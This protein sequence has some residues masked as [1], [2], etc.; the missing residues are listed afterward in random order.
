VAPG[1]GATA[2]VDRRRLKTGPPPAP[3]PATSELRRKL[4]ELE[5]EAE[6]VELSWTPWPPNSPARTQ[7]GRQRCRPWPRWRGLRD[8]R[9]IVNWMKTNATLSM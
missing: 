2:A 8:R 4:Q 3:T 7:P 9:R 6:L 1:G 5:I